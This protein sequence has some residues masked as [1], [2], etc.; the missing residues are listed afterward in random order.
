MFKISMFLVGI[1]VA[2]CGAGGSASKGG[3]FTC[4][5]AG[6]QMGEYLLTQSRVSNDPKYRV[7]AEAATTT[8]LDACTNGGW[9]PNAIR[10]VAEYDEEGPAQCLANG[11]GVGDNLSDCPL[12]SDT[13][14][15]A[16][17]TGFTR[18]QADVYRK[19]MLA[20]IHCDPGVVGSITNTLGA[21][22]H[23]GYAC[24]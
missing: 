5:D 12:T 1:M 13:P 9:S 8:T 23:I 4:Q 19:A 15:G 10:C 16:A 11:H 7:F 22:V 3:K 17:C 21:T 2:A 18:V 24:Q 6:K 20:V 14:Y